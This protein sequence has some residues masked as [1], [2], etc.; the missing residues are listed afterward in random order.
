[1]DKTL[2]TEVDT[3]ITQRILTFYSAL[4]RR[5]QIKHVGEKGPSAILPL[6]HCNQSEHM[7]QDVRLEGPAL[8]QGDPLQS[9]LGGHEHG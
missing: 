8:H 6:F 7:R 1:M 2:K 4:I 9:P 5:G 3:L